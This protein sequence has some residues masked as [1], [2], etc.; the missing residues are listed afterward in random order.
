MIQQPSSSWLHW[1]DAHYLDVGHWYPSSLGNR[2]HQGRVEEYVCCGGSRGVVEVHV[3][4]DADDLGV[5]AGVPCKAP[6]A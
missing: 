4:R 3:E 6:A 5:G 2:C 1:G